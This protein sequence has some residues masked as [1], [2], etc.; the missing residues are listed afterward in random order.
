[1]YEVPLAI[2]SV[3]YLMELCAKSSSDPIALNTYD[4]SNDAEVQADPLDNAMSFRAINKDSPER[5]TKKYMLPS[6]TFYFK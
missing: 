2:D 5:Y 1:M 4:G 3:F 6:Y